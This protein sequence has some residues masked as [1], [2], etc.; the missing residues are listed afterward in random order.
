M[1]D[2][3]YAECRLR[4]GLGIS[5]G[6]IKKLR[7][8]CLK[9]GTDFELVDCDGHRLT[10]Y[11]AGGVATVLDYMLHGEKNAP[12]TR[13]AAA[14]VC[15]ESLMRSSALRGPVSAEKQAG[16]PVGLIAAPRDVPDAVMSVERL[17]K[18]RRILMGGMKEVWIR[19]YG[20]GFFHRTGIDPRGPHRIQ[21]HDSA[22]FIPGMEVPCRWIEAELWE[23]TRRMPRFRGR[24]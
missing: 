17:T 23:C 21:V 20:Y 16:S 24:W 10:A 19:K 1:N 15:V 6:L 7:R 4:E 9:K 18:N 13:Q 8:E 2:F 3:I 14:G 22:K 12:S 5:D 11:T